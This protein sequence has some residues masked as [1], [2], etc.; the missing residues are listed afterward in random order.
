MRYLVTGAAGFIGSH[1]AETLLEQGHD[2][3]ALDSFTDYYDPRRK[4]ENVAGIAVL[5]TDILEADLDD[6]L[7][8]VDGVFHLAGQPG[9]RAHRDAVLD[10]QLHRFPHHRH[11][12]IELLRGQFGEIG[13]ARAN[14]TRIF[15]IPIIPVP[16]VWALIRQRR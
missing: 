4:R 1:L 6:V 9:V 16:V 8:R 7:A 11:E 13:N 12:T 10:G 14:F 15:E 3:V 2:V 5:E